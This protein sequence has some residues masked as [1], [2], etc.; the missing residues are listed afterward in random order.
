L[1][2]I[3]ALPR[4]TG[5]AAIAAA[6]ERCA[7]ELSALGYTVTE[8]PFS[9]SAFPGRFAMPL[10]GAA[11]AM[12]VGVAGMWALAGLRF[13]P[14]TVLLGAIVATIAI[15]RWMTRR[16]VLAMP[17][18]RTSGV[19]LEAAGIVLATVL[20]VVE[21]TTGAGAPESMWALAGIV[22]L[23]GAVPVGL[24]MVGSKSPGA[25]DNASG[26]ATVVA[27]ARQ[28][29]DVNGVG[30]LITDAEELGLAGARAWAMQHD[31]TT[32]INC[33]GVD[34]HGEISVM[35]P[36]RLSER[37]AHALRSS[38]ARVGPHLPGV[39]TDAIAFSDAGH[40]SA[41]VSRG[42]L[43][44]FLRVHSRRDD[45]NHLRGRGVEPTASVIAATVRHLMRATS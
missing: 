33:D 7:A 30:V 13:A 4:P 38:G 20:A 39:L 29:V 24:S 16:G 37:L 26:V 40:E 5:G 11:N 15:A 18:L 41:T 42:S 19:N 8:R 35:R 14:V 36:G 45:S 32:V 9:F 44:S 12:A 21:A 34:D 25:L 6:R 10:L 28:L 43:G 31:A 17:V 1:R 2:D 22:T 3:A 23:S 27:A